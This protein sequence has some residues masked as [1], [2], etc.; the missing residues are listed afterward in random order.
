MLT[1]DVDWETF[2]CCKGTKINTEVSN[3]PLAF[4]FALFPFFFCNHWGDYFPESDIL[5]GRQVLLDFTSEA[6]TAG[7]Y[8]ASQPPQQPHEDSFG[9]EDWTV[10]KPVSYHDSSTL[11]VNS[12]TKRR[13][14]VRMFTLWRCFEFL[15]FFFII[16]TDCPLYITHKTLMASPILL[17]PWFPQKLRLE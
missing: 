2:H 4:V 13:H 16:H 7:C 17:D 10:G 6:L 15:V 9:V 3:L 1:K 5:Q 11:T 12:D 8:N 14:T